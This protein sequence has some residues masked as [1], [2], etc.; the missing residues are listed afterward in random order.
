MTDILLATYNGERYIGE[1]LRSIEAQTFEDWRLIV[2]DDGSTDATVDIV[3]EFMER[4][5]EGR[6]ELVV[7]VPGT[8]S[9][10]DNFMKALILCSGDYTMF[11]DQ[12]DV[13]LETK[14]EDTLGKMLEAEAAIRKE[15]GT[16]E[17]EMPYPV[18]VHTDAFVTDEQLKITDRSFMKHMGFKKELSRNERL[19]QNNC[20]GATCMMNR[21]LTEM[22]QLAAPGSVHMTMHDHFASLIASAFGR[23]V[24]LDRP[25]MLYRQH[26]DNSVGAVKK[27]DAIGSGKGRD[28]ARADFRIMMD[29]YCEQ[30]RYFMYLFEPYMNDVADLKLFM[31]FG[32]L[33]RKGK[34]GRVSF[35]LRHGIMKTGKTKKAGQILWI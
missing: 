34:A 23:V 26:G 24:Y 29:R 22:M 8:G 32:R 5:P 31:D 7:N 20:V 2:S 4:M 25:L 11:C 13:W 14:I 1:L 12:D 6:V 28:A 21:A 27:T 18:L 9:A 35:C 30:A 10:R 19:I 33:Y 17:W 15:T 3:R 16:P